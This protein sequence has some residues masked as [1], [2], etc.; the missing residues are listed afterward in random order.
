[1][2]IIGASGHARVVIDALENLG[3]AIEGIF[4]SDEYLTSCLGY[5]VFSMEKFLPQ[6]TSEAVIAIGNNVWR[7]KVSKIYD[8]SVKWARVIH[9]SAV[10]SRHTVLGHGSVIMAGA[11]IQANATVGQHS[12]INTKASVDHDCEVGDFTLIAPDVTLC[13][14]VRIGSN[15]LIGAGATVI[16]GV[17]IGDDCFIGAGSVVLRD[18]RSGEKVNGVI[19]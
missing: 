16:P 11:I 17:K 10:V 15:C 1:M 7:K 19:K 14:D 9:P 5:P 12:I 4:D 2:F 6:P 3:I 13:G 18:V 8:G